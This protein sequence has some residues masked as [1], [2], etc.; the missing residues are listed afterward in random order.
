MLNF[1]N[2][3]MSKTFTLQRRYCTIGCFHSLPHNECLNRLCWL[4]FFFFFPKM[5]FLYSLNYFQAEALWPFYNKLLAC[6]TPNAGLKAKRRLRVWGWGGQSW[7]RYYIFGVNSEIQK[8]FV[9][10]LPQP[11]TPSHTASYHINKKGCELV[12][13]DSTGGTF[14]MGTMAHPEKP[15]DDGSTSQSHPPP[16]PNL[17][18]PTPKV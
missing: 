4:L 1:P 3:P 8:M 15:T 12:K 9:Q 13:P 17:S 5:T 7:E 18:F 16:V 14:K 2:F 11:G 10:P 6:D